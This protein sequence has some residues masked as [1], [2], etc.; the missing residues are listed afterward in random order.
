MSEEIVAPLLSFQRDEG[1]LLSR[2][3]AK[4]LCHRFERFNLFSSVAPSG[5][6]ENIDLARV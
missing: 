6:A 3:Q 4:R 2:A 1:T 5:S